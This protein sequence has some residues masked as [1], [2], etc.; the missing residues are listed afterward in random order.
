M[1]APEEFLEGAFSLFRCCRDREIEAFLKNKAIEYYK[2]GFCSVYLLFDEAKLNEGI[3][4]LEG[5]FT[6]SHKSLLFQPTTAKTKRKKVQGGIKATAKTA[7]FVLIGQLCKYVDETDSSCLTI[8]D[9]LE[10]VYEVVRTSNDLI[11]CNCVLVECK[12]HPKLNNIYESHGFTY[13]QSDT[14]EQYFIKV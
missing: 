9:I 5:Y 8:K 7:H 14:L 2:R 1:Q 10:C 3:Y 13:L 11:P 12:K 6:L 4:K